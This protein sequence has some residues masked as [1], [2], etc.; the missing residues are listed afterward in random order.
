ML[1]ADPSPNPATP[2]TLKT[3][4]LKDEGGDILSCCEGYKIRSCCMAP[5]DC[6][7]LRRGRLALSLG[8]CSAYLL[9]F[10]VY[11]G[12]LQVI[13]LNGFVSPVRG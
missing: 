11:K 8:K 3:G 10:S 13:I 6:R 9:A 4:G 2:W 5:T 12:K 1:A 7:G